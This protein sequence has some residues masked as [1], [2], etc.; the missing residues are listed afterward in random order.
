MCN[1]NLLERNKIKH[2]QSKKHKYYSNLILNRYVTKNVE[3]IKLKDIFNPYFTAHTR[4]FNLFTV[5]ILLFREK[6][7]IAITF[8]CLFVCL[9]VSRISHE[10]LVGF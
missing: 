5:S 7:D 2:N 3:V 9:F 10:L 6:R 1:T 4:K 8:V